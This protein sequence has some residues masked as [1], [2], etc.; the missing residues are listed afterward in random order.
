MSLKDTLKKRKAEILKE[1]KAYDKL[2]EE[3]SEIND[4]LAGIAGP[5]CNGCS[6][7]CDICRTGPY[8]R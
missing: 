5:Q 2:K 6:G 7:G 8:Y 1:L 4:A 3:L